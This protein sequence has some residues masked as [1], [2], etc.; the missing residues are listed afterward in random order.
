MEGKPFRLDEHD[1]RLL[2]ELDR[3]SSLPLSALAKRMRKS[4]Q[5]A[6]FRQKRLE[7]SG[8][9]TGYTAIVD[10]AR[11]GYLSFRIY[12]K[13]HQMTAKAASGLVDYIKTLPN[14]WTI[15]LLHGKWDL[16][17]F[18]GAKDA[19]EVHAV[20]DPIMERYKEKVERYNFTLYAPIY[21]FNRA[22]FMGRE[23]PV[24]VREYGAGKPE[25]IDDEDWKIIQAYA[26]GVRQPL[27]G[28]A[29]KVGLSPETVRRRIA[30]LEKRRI[31]CG[32]KIGIDIGKLGY[33]AYRLDFELLSSKKWKGL[34]EY[35]K[36]HPSI[37]QVQKTVGHMDFETE[38]VVKDLAEL[39]A[40]IE[41]VKTRFGDVVNNVEYFGYST[42]HL[43]NYIPD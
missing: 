29:K 8:V 28:V 39:L 19:G 37:Y 20:W 2:Y 33:T 1:R 36:Q 26:P 5:F 23:M 25:K 27:V 43:L 34:F 16:A 10:M 24:E 14:V 9:I 32:Y 15:T 21:N 4:K 35:C 6:L 41:D 30:S 13:F 11:L 3:D 40:I 12:L 18:I 17:I 31:I 7:Q 42:Y 38:V 22:F